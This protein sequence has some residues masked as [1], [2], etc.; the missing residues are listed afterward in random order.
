MSE[1]DKQDEDACPGLIFDE[2]KSQISQ[3]AEE[4]ERQLQTER[5]RMKK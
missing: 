1:G 2:E 3:K 4:E 5:I